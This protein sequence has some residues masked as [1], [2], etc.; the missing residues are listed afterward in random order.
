MIV[1]INHSGLFGMAS[2]IFT[3]Q[4]PI[5]KKTLN[6]LYFTDLVHPIF[7]ISKNRTY[8]FVICDKYIYI[9]C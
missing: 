6:F 5:K 9:V 3:D 2:R 8:S 1:I 4:G 7:N